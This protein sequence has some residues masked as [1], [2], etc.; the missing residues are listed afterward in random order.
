MKGRQKIATFTSAAL[1]GLFGGDVATVA[2]LTGTAITHNYMS[3]AV[4]Q[5]DRKD[6]G[7][8]RE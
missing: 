4:E 2:H 1:E 7:G 6:F 8:S 3:S 5:A